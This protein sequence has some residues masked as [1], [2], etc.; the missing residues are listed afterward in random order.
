MAE[1]ANDGSAAAGKGET[2]LSEILRMM[3]KKDAADNVVGSIGMKAGMLAYLLASGHQAGSVC[4][5]S[6]CN[7][8]VGCKMANHVSAAAA[9]KSELTGKAV[10]AQNLV[11]PYHFWALGGAD[12]GLSAKPGKERIAANTPAGQCHVA[13]FTNELYVP[14][15]K[16]DEMFEATPVYEALTMVDL[17]TRQLAANFYAG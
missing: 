9:S 6:C 3:M 13:Y 14:G 7:A 4:M 16:G 8:S 15:G 12:G 5:A 2:G 10:V 11:F 17:Q 1:G